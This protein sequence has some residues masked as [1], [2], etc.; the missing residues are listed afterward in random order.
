MTR[1]VTLLLA[2][3]ALWAGTPSASLAQT[4]GCACLHNRVGQAI[5]FRYRWGDQP[6]QNRTLNPGMV[7]S[8]CWAYGAGIHSSPPLQFMLDRDMSGG[9]SFTN[10]NI[11][12]IQSNTTQCAGVPPQG[13]YHVAFQPNTGNQFLH[14]V[15]GAGVATAPGPGPG[16]GPGVGNQFGC[17]CV[18]NGVGIPIRFQY[19]WGNN[20]FTTRTLNPG[21]VYAFCWPYG[22][23]IHAS[24]PLHFMLDRDM[25]QGASF[26]NYSIVRIQS[27]TNQCAGVPRA[28]QYWVRF[29]P[30]TN[31][32]FLHVTR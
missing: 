15:R 23:G 31:N 25:G 9:T 22:A 26:T 12:R 21:M 19:R 17:A 8:F 24:P 16:P 18:N 5:N 28:G 32:Q 30:G 7:Y 11:T 1:I 3:F 10:Y 2:A 13:H 27:P 4:H 14:V 20:A 6:F 29:Q